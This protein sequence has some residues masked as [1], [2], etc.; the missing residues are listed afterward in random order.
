MKEKARRSIAKALSWRISGS[1][2]TMAIAFFISGKAGVAV[3][4]GLAE[5]VVKIGM[6]YLHERL[7]NRISF[8]RVKENEPDY[9]I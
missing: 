8:G 6:F 1:I 4:I 5:F 3:T 9:T 2:G 7:W